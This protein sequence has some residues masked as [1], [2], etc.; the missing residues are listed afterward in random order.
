[1]YAYIVI[2]LLSWNKSAMV[3]CPCSGVGPWNGLGLG[4]GVPLGT[5]ASISGYP[6][7]GVQIQRFESASYSAQPTVAVVPYTPALLTA[8][9]PTIPTVAAVAVADRAVGVETVTA[10]ATVAPGVVTVDAVARPAVEA[11]APVGF[12]ANECG[13]CRSPYSPLPPAGVAA[14]RSLLYEA[15]APYDQ[16]MGPACWGRGC[17]TCAAA[18]NWWF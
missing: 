15:N 2:S 10:P 6:G 7:V 13:C 17:G 5:A 1:M 8:V 18:R 3:R 12:R 9:V 14:W 16:L 11:V 4:Y